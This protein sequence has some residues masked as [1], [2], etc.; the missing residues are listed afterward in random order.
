MR[1]VGGLLGTLLVLVGLLTA[2]DGRTDDDEQAGC[3]GDCSTCPGKAQH[4]A[5]LADNTKLVLQVDGMQGAEDSQMIRD[6]LMQLDGVALAYA[7]PNLGLV[8]VAH[9]PAVADADELAGGVGE[10]GYAVL[11][12][13]YRVAPLPGLAKG[14]TR[15]VVYVALLDD[16]DCA[17]S[18]EAAVAHVP[19]VDASR[20]DRLFNILIVD[21]DPAKTKPE[22][23]KQ[24]VLKLGYSAGLP[25]EQMT[26]PEES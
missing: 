6:S 22:A 25:G 1:V 5:A 13:A 7:D 20:L 18:I 9:D 15:G 19:G 16:E 26:M 17:A 14:H 12:E 10:L 24:A 8:W 21:Y 11:G 3:E 4:L 23:V 2:V